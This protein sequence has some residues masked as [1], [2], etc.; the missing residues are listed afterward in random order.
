M[1]VQSSLLVCTE[2]V[3]I[4]CTGTLLVRIGI[5]GITRVHVH[6]LYG[7]WVLIDTRIGRFL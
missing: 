4:D 2:F 3:S 1:A 6:T 5:Y 7:V